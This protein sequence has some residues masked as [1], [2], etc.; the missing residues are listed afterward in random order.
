MHGS[1]PLA[2]ERVELPG[3]RGKPFTGVT[4]GPDRHLYAGTL[5]GEI[6]RWPIQSDGT[7][8]PGQVITSLQAANG[9][10]RVLIGL[11][12]DP[13]ATADDLVLW[14]T[15]TADGFSDGPDWAGKL[16]R[17]RGPD[18]QGVQDYV[19]HLPRSTR[20]HLTNQI[21]FGPDGAIYFTQGSNS[22]MGAPD[23]AWGMRPER[24][25]NAAVLRLDVRALPAIPLD[26]QTDEGGAY[27]PWA[28]GAPLTIYASGVRNAYDLVWHR[29]GQLYV[30]TNGSA[31]G[32][33][34]PASPDPV[35]CARRVDHEVNGVY[36][37][38]VVPGIPRVDQI[39]HD[40][41][42]RVMQGGY[43]GHPNPARC[44]WVMN[45][46]NPTGEVDVAEVPQ[47]PVGTLADRNWRGA[48]FDFGMNQSPNG[49][50]E[51]RGSAFGGALNGKLLVVRYSRGSDIVALTP[52]PQGDI[53]DVQVGIPG[54]GG[55]RGPLDLAED[56]QTGFIYLAELG[57]E[58][59]TLLRPAP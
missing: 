34:S 32:G 12:F 28:P 29:N 57:A 18:L 37:G 46:G 56:P 14:T 35:S 55:F 54:F 1:P 50:I 13:S 5:A 48:A 22:A 23:S 36:D 58:R 42:F 9:G 43:Y 33:A 16:T 51:Y 40:Y 44:E 49:I 15:H 4:V 39:Q 30:P 24:L 20:D 26:A 2:F 8:G 17:L 53:T 25:L 19:V 59:L 52:D 31:P 7:L 21:D 27:D 38:P 47:Y 11:R 41:L 3:A 6:A 45:G 10:E